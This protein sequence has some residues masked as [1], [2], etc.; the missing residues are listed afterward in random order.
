MRAVSVWQG[1]AAKVNIICKPSGNSRYSH[2]QNMVEV[3]RS[4]VL[5]DVD[6]VR[7][8]LLLHLFAAALRLSAPSKPV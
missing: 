3:Q 7:R 1:S 6:D 4:C 5:M 2:S 8:R